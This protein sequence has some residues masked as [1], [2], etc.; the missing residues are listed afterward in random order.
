MSLLSTPMEK[1]T[2]GLAKHPGADQMNKVVT[3]GWS[4]QPAPWEAKPSTPNWE[5]PQGPKLS[6]IN[7]TFVEY[8]LTVS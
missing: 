8:Q 1:R 4:Y 5:R 3:Q 2:E 6:S 7:I